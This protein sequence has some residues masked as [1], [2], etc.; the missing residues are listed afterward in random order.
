MDL[1]F[2]PADHR[3][4]LAEIRLGVPRVMTQRHE[5]FAHPLTPT[6]HIVLDDGDPTSEAVLVAQTLED[7]FRGMT[8]LGRAEFV[9]LQDLVDDPD[10][11]I[12]LRPLRR[13][14]AAVAR[15]NR[16]P[17]HLGNRPRIYPKT[18]PRLPV[19][20]TLP[21]NGKANATIQFHALHPPTL[22]QTGKGVSADAILLRRNQTNRPLQ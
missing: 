8:L 6:Q 20:H 19:A 15:W 22:C 13:S 10:K 17:H 21:L 12:Q 4:R 16:E 7:P 9:V 11:P 1:P 5:H 3:Q 18:T 2:H 14:A